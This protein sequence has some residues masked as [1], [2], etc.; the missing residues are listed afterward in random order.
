[1]QARAARPLLL[2]LFLFL[3][4]P[5]AYW[6]GWQPTRGD[7]VDLPS[8]QYAARL[9][10][11][12]HQTP[13][14]EDAFAQASAEK[15]RRVHPFLYPPP[16]LLALWP[17]SLMSGPAGTAVFM[18]L[19]HLCFLG[20]I[21]LLL[22][23]ITPL[24]QEERASNLVLL[25]GLIYLLLFDPAAVT[26]DVGQINMFALFFICLA[27]AA[28]KQGK[29][30]WHVALPLAVAILLKTYP[31]LLL[32][33]LLFRG[34]FREI[35]LTMI[36]FTIFVAIA[37]LALPTEIWSSW[38]RE[39]L[40][41]GGYANNAIAAAAPWNQNINAFVTRLFQANPFSDAPL[42][43][44]SLAR[45]IA[46]VLAIIVLVVTAY[47][48]FRSSRRQDVR[49]WDLEIG[50][51]LLML[52]LIAPLSWEHHFVYVLPALLLAIS[53][54]VSKE[55]NGKWAAIVV[56][57]LCIIAWKI[58]FFEI[59]KLRGWGTLWISLKF[60]P[61]FALWLFFISR[62]RSRQVGAIDLNRPRAV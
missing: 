59:S 53:W 10:W 17:L 62:L 61:A 13:Y 52:F 27:L 23:K 30:P 34:K 12:E 32:M 41:N 36:F 8:Y 55:I 43:H 22:M 48:C 5:V 4:I 39:V 9:A 38:F 47:F 29:A 24:P 6:H 40:P 1:M 11:V 19:S 26:L 57:A 15:G 33:P 2:T 58:P 16:S 28:I 54:L 60:Y 31:V 56:A 7:I 50:A 42:E 18:V 20:S 49:N 35:A 14:G 44:A 25:L 46:T 51:C 21:A 45:P 3:Y 37:A